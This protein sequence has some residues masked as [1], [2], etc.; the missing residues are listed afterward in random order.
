M[1]HTRK[2]LLI[3]IIVVTALLAIGTF[4]ARWGVSVRVIP[5]DAPERELVVDVLDDARALTVPDN[6]TAGFSEQDTTDAITS[7]FDRVNVG[8]LDEEFRVIDAELETL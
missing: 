5:P 4:I 2:T 1:Q 6:A 8:D 3:G 7:D